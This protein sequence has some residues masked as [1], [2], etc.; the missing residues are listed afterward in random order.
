MPADGLSAFL[1]SVDADAAAIERAD[2]ARETQGIKARAV[3][4][5]PR[6]LVLVVTVCR[7]E[8]CG[9]LTRNINPNVLVRYEEDNSSNA[10]QF[11]Y[12]DLTPFLGLRRERLTH[13]MTVPFCEQC[14]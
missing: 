14:F 3:T 7:C 2:K 12:R 9:S 6:A 5:P 4:S 8:A 10:A 13:F 11:R 1:A